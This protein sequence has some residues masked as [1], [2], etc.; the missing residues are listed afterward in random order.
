MN[1]KASSRVPGGHY[2][3]PV[4]DTS[5]L[6]DLESAS[7]VGEGSEEEEGEEIGD[8]G[9]LVI[10]PIA[11]TMAPATEEQGKPERSDAE[12]AAFAIKSSSPSPQD[13]PVAPDEPEVVYTGMQVPGEEPS[14]GMVWK[15]RK[16][17]PI[18]PTNLSKAVPEGAYSSLADGFLQAHEPALTKMHAL[19]SEYM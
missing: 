13:T 4:M 12:L 1:A 11:P 10:K 2:L 8:L 6:L 17:R 3:G 9:D 16:Q 19:L 15:P 5:S 18:R 7:V 14:K